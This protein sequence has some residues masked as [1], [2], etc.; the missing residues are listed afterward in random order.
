MKLNLR[1]KLVIALLAVSLTS[2]AVTGL[3]GFW[4][5]RS[6][7][8]D[9]A[10]DRM[11]TLRVA[12]QGE[13][14][15][16]FDHVR[17][18]VRFVSRNP[19]NIEAAD[20]FVKAFEALRAL[21]ANQAEAAEI[22]QYYERSFMP[23][24]NEHYE[25]GVKIDS[26]LP[27]TA[28]ARYL[29]SRYIVRNPG[30]LY[31]KAKHIDAGDATEY[32]AVHKKRHPVFLNMANELDYYDFMIV[33]PETHEIVYSVEKEIDLGTSLR[34]GPFSKTKLAQ[35]VNSIDA[36]TDPDKVIFVDFEFY[37]P[38]YNHPAM[39]I[40]SPIRDG[41]RLAGIL[42]LQFSPDRINKIMTG[43]KEEIET[44]GLG[45]TGEVLL[46]G[47]DTLMRS[48]SRFFLENSGAYSEDLLAAGYDRSVVD[49][50]KSLGT[51]ILTISRNPD[52]I[53]RVFERG[54][55]SAITVNQ[56]KRNSLASY[57]PIRIEGLDW[58]IVAHLDEYEALA[59]V[60]EFLR[61]ALTLLL[62][63]LGLTGAVALL[64]GGAISRPIMRLTQ[65]VRAFVNGFRDVRVKI[66]T[67]DE[68]EEL[69]NAFN[70]M[71]S[72]IGTQEIR[73]RRQVSENRKLLE[74]FLPATVLARL[75]GKSGDDDQTP[76]RTETTLTFVEIEG[77]SQ[78]FEEFDAEIVLNMTRQLIESFDEAALR[79]GVEKLSSSGAG[80]LAAC[81][82]TR[83]HFDHTQRILAFVQELE[84]IVT[85]FNAQHVTSLHLSAGVHRGPV[86]SGRIGRND[87]VNELWAKTVELAT[88]IEPTFGRS[89]IRVSDDVYERV[90]SNPDYRF[91]RDTTT[92]ETNAWTL[93]TSQ[94]VR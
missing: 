60:R 81:G 27:D 65:A 19:A 42:V 55:E 67:G 93:L 54:P 46:V 18:H 90:C 82:I 86:G 4:R 21:P 9:A 59:S 79:H 50:M 37:V 62:G 16:Y 5:S 80:Y 58:G 51:T 49:K 48:D 1:K 84:C 68:V 31:E 28:A 8:I 3:L 11:T 24:L 23:A 83:S 12:K 29:Q 64:V 63:T 41:Q 6:A 35:S 15:R 38:S 72:E 70:N 78:L 87:F 17:D 66:D 53:K 85:T 47:K 92:I 74:N 14:L 13:V 25:T 69:A 75:R 71:A 34:S 39:F 33:H 44:A 2:C 43:G 77:L 36:S 40:V 73:L 10:F 7:L 57:S 89:A 32:S 88:E 52:T 30:S 56:L 22:R 76:Y 91:E 20:E 45:K 26:I 94:K 61:E